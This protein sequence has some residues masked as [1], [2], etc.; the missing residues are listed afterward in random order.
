MFINDLTIPF[1]GLIQYT[2]RYQQAH[3][4]YTINKDKIRTIVSHSLGSV[5]AHHLILENVQL[6]GR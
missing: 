1:R 5:I 4:L 2:D 6:K 3:Q